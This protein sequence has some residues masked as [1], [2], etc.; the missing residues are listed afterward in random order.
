MPKILSIQFYDYLQNTDF[1]KS[2]EKQ[3]CSGKEL[4]NCIFSL[5]V[6]SRK[7]RKREEDRRAQ[8]G[9]NKNKHCACTGCRPRSAWVLWAQE[10]S[11]ALS[12]QEDIW[13][14]LKIEGTAANKRW[15][16]SCYG[17]KTANTALNILRHLDTQTF[18]LW[19]LCFLPSIPT[20]RMAHLEIHN[21]ITHQVST[22]SF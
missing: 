11:V 10:Y 6:C 1:S 13:K 3:D 15:V 22:D 14:C 17:E 5:A 16:R 18:P 9:K 21:P 20:P 12:N 4:K 7:R 2:H 8:P 19:G